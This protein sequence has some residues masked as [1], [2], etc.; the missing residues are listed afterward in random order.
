VI[1]G[2]RGRLAATGMVIGVVTALS[3]GP[4]SAATG[5]LDRTILDANGDN[6]LEL[7][8]GERHLVREDLAKVGS[9]RA[10]RR[11]QKI[12]FGQLTD[13]HVV[14]E[15]SPLR[16]EFLDRVGPPFT[17]AW[18][19]QEGITAQ[20]LERM[21]RRVREARSSIDG[22]A[23]ELV[24]TT[25]DNTDNTQLNE[26]R[27]YI[28]LL[29]GGKQVNPD[30]GV[31]FDECSEPRDGLYDGVRGGNEYYE[32]D[33]SGPGVD[34]R[35]YSPN[36]ADNVMAESKRIQSR[37]FPGLYEDMNRP[38]AAT[39]LGVPWYGVFGNHDGLVQGNQ[40]RNSAFEA[41]ATGCNKPSSLSP[42]AQ[43]EIE[44]IGRDGVTEEDL[45]RVNQILFSEIAPLLS[46]NPQN[47]GGSF[48]KV[49]SDPMRVPLKKADY[50]RQHF[51]TT[52]A[53]VGHGFTQAN[54]ESG[55]GNFVLKP[56]K[57][58]RF[59]VLD[60]INEGGGDGGNIDDPQFRWMH[61][62]LVEADK[63]RE[64][65][66]LFAHHSLQTMDQE[67]ESPFPPGD[68]GGEATR[69]VHLGGAEDSA[70]PSTSA[71]AEPTAAETV[72]CLF[73][74]HPSVIAYVNGHEHN[75]RVTPFGPVGGSTRAGTTS[76]HGF[77]EVNTA[78]HIDFPQQ[79]RLIDLFD[80][81]D[82][83][84]SIFGT[85]VDHASDPDPGLAASPGRLPDL[86]AS[87]SRELAFNDPDADEDPDP[88]T[89]E[90]ASS[91]RGKPE[92]RNVELLVATPFS[93]QAGPQPKPR[94]SP[95]PKPRPRPKRRSSVRCG[96]GPN[97][98]SHQGGRRGGRQQCHRR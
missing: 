81:R 57:G 78:S 43:A 35:G 90:A 34:G 16:V 66:M 67:A 40:P 69:E 53:P 44:L 37:D 32:P 25:G 70:C 79:S 4:A 82:G 92:D 39:G 2:K 72:R 87:I 74:R 73:L 46:G 5:T 8:P 36:E 65:V 49:P 84:V 23:L 42:A 19:P 59:I 10:A 52:G 38:F 61:R 31:G 56:R 83:T 89:E 21:V 15:E 98:R 6:R 62:Q 85:V 48:M 30:S 17:A 75:N 50:I 63:A 68:Q 94:P 76:R 26:T 95:N 97:Q 64:L 91:A 9:G 88:G 45:R 93:S 24:M 51:S 14:D 47:F 29:D 27:W 20:V 60:S 41:I 80:N 33:A 86:L 77:W 22:R 28:D 55:Q 96:G 58:L 71:T 54:I 12:F 7:G 1:R 18:R 13:T 11:Q 3:A